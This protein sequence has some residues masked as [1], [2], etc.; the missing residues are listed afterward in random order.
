M[1][2][3]YQ[4]AA[5]HALRR[6]DAIAVVEG[7]RRYTFGA[8]TQRV[9]RYAAC[10]AGLGVRRGD[11][12]CAV[13]DNSA[14]YLAL[15]HATAVGGFILVPANVRL[16]P[17][18]FAWMVSHCAPNI[19]LYDTKNRALADAARADAPPTVAWLHMDELDVEG[20][21]DRCA[22]PLTERYG[23]VEDTDVALIIY[24]SGTTALP[25]GAMLTHGNL[26]W[27]AINFQLELGID[28]TCRATLATPLFHIGGFGVLN[29]PVLYAGGCLSI[30]PR[31]DPESIIAHL[32][33]RPP[34]H[35]FLLS[36]MWVSLTDHPDFPELRFPAVKYVQTASSPLGDHRQA[37]IRRAFPE[38]EFGWG[39]GMTESCVTTFKNR[40]TA[41]ILS[42]SG[43]VGYGWR[44]I[45]YRLVDEDRNVLTG[46]D[47][48]GELEVRGPTVFAGYWNDAE[49]TAATLT[50]D[51][52]LRTGDLFRIDEE[53]Y[54]YFV[55]RGKDMVKTGGE[56][57]AALEVETC[58]IQHPGVSEA[59]VFG[60]PHDYWG[61]ELRAAVVAAPGASVDPEELRAFC[62]ERLTGFKVPKKITVER[63]LPKSSSGKIQ[64]FKLKEAAR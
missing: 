43:S 64:K 14:D 38:A 49:A 47:R 26:V 46:T 25:K 51:G 36:A 6:P 27:N 30:L 52:W 48:Q 44:H 16:S 13:L 45:A 58:L 20:A 4:T 2:N 54:G 21:S 8:F 19:V 62:R 28:E 7:E 56:N 59:A 63:E 10:L 33:E 32:R 18:E 15:F 50:P 24:T 41:E 12:V 9:R 53:G 55:G 42:H 35:L 5:Y 57:V 60:V 40:T 23:A 39:F 17:R 34:T 3:I 61:E 22:D 37:L 31:F 11:R 1:P 29:G